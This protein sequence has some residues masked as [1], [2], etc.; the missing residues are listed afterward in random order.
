MGKSLGKN[1]SKTRTTCIFSIFFSGC[2]QPK[3]IHIL[4]RTQRY[5][6]LFY[7]YAC[8]GQKQNKNYQPSCISR[9]GRITKSRSFM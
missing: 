7:Q 6:N 1:A 4:F 9:K 3:S 2:K 5:N 8:T